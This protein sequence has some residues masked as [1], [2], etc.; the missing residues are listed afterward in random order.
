MS[1]DHAHAHV[2]LCLLLTG[3]C[4]LSYRF[5][6][7]RLEPGDLGFFPPNLPHTETFLRPQLPY[8]LAWWILARDRLIVQVTE[9]RS[10]KFR[11]VERATLRPMGQEVRDARRRLQ[12]MV[13]GPR[14][15]GVL[16]VKEALVTLTLHLMRQMIAQP[17]RPHGVIEQAKEFI[18]KHPNDAL[19]ISD[20][21][22]AVLLSPNYLTSLFRTTTGLS[23][24]NYIKRERIA[25]AKAMLADGRRSVKD[26]AYALGFEDPYTFSRT[27]KRVEGVSPLHYR[28]MGGHH[29]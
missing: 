4:A 26:V 7:Y 5:K 1:E 16:A 17:G 8:R 6:H 14:P 18:R 28:R 20:V 21:A 12:Q 25:R 29:G 27:F 11:F 24:G 10:G 2:E 3:R 19:S 23:L 22:R 15:P 9:Y 13:Q